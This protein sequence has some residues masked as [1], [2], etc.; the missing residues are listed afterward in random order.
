[1]FKLCDLKDASV[2]VWLVAPKVTIGRAGNCDLAIADESVAKL[3][4]EVTVEGDVLTL[5]HLAES[6]QTLL[7]GTPVQGS[8]PLKR[9]DELQ[10]GGGL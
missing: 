7:N 5:H 3:H 10:I 2:S 1:M 8:C 4:A 6:G 9:D